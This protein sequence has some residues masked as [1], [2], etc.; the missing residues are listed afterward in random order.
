M[1]LGR[2]RLLRESMA[3]AAALPDLEEAHAAAASRREVGVA[4]S[5]RR[6]GRR[7]S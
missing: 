2:R 4:E 7:S 6:R 3:T 1:K 5:R